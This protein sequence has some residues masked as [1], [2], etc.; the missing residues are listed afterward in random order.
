MS[1]PPTPVAKPGSSLKAWA[2][3]ISIAVVIGVVIYLIV[4]RVRQCDAKNEEATKKGPGALKCDESDMGPVPKCGNWMC[5]K[6]CKKSYPLNPTFVESPL[7]HDFC[8]GMDVRGK[9][10]TLPKIFYDAK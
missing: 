10:Q 2:I 5:A 7:N 8:Q 3:G 9:T 6:T 1:T 4:K